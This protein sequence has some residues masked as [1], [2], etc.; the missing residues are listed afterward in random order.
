MRR[1]ARSGRGL[2]F[3]KR[4]FTIRHASV[5]FSSGSI[6]RRLSIACPFLCQSTRLN[7]QE[8]CYAELGRCDR[9]PLRRYHRGL[10]AL[11]EN[12]FGGGGQQ[13]RVKRRSFEP[14]IFSL[15]LRNEKAA[16]IY[17]FPLL[18]PQTSDVND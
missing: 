18:C 9:A 6:S 5:P 13:S 4:R 10:N 17:R 12:R 15:G 11:F 16:S 3:V 8:R 1:G 14:G 7:P 2:S